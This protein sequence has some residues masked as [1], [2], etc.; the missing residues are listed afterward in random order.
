MSYRRA[1]CFGLWISGLFISASGMA[2]TYARKVPKPHIIPIGID[3][4]TY[5][6]NLVEQLESKFNIWTCPVEPEKSPKL[7]P[8]ILS[9]ES[10]NG[11]VFL[12]WNI[13]DTTISGFDV[14]RG[15]NGEMP[16]Q[17]AH[18]INPQET[19]WRDTTV[20]EGIYYTYYVKAVFHTE[21]QNL[22]SHPAKILV[23][24]SESV[25]QFEDVRND[26][27]KQRIYFKWS[28]P[29]KPVHSYRILVT[30]KG[31]TY[32]LCSIDGLATEMAFH[33]TKSLEHAVF[34]IETV[35]MD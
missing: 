20:S 12:Q 35:P 21:N 34:S 8:Q 15:D 10:V 32:T 26:T 13:G 18:I 6:S 4:P 17:M 33:Y 23:P 2:D 30:Q 3:N 7:V 5:P 31:S 29:A 24:T 9:C 19:H 14:Y 11:D 1:I 16:A 28:A 27:E 22:W 25:V